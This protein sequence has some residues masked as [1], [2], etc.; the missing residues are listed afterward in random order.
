MTKVVIT[1]QISYFSISFLNLP[2]KRNHFIKHPMPM[3][4]EVTEKPKGYYTPLGI[5]VVECENSHTQKLI[6]IY[7]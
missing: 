1:S 5:N 7:L 6:N 2:I 3:L 4:Y